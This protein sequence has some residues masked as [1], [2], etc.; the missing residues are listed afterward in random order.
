MGLNVTPLA[1]ALGA[2]IE[3]ADP[4]DPGLDFGAVRDAVHRYEVVFFPRVHLSEEEHLAFGRRFGTPSIFPVARL[5]GATEPKMTVIED[6]PD[7]RNKADEWHTDL[8]WTATPPAYALLHMEVL[9][10]RGGDTLWA[11]AT[12]AYDALSPL[13]QEFFCGLSV[14]HDHEIFSREVAERGGEAAQALLEGLDRDYP[15]VEHPLVRTHPETGRRALLYA[16]QFARHIKGLEPAESRAV[17]AFI[18]DHV[19]EPAFHC[20]WRWSEGDLA[21]WDER[22][23]LHRAAADHFGHRR[24]IRR[25]EIDGD[26]PFFDPTR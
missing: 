18:E 23:T 16:A 6:A 12:A 8:T 11:S 21:I 10:A 9:P 25:L 15:P 22:S 4:R 2:V 1:G 24:V 17:L 13:M 20:R 7:A 5:L 26:R 14:V 19:K 3:D